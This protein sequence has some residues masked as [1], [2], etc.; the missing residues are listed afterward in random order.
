MSNFENKKFVHETAYRGE[1]ALQKLGQIHVTIAGA[2]TLGSNL[3]VSLVRQGIKNMRVIDMDR[4]EEQNLGTQV[5][6]AS[7]V[8]AL[9]VDAL[10]N[11]VYQNVECEIESINKELTAKNIKKLLKNTD[12]VIDAFDN[13][14]SRR[15]L[16]EYCSGN[17]IACLHAGLFEDYGEVVWNENYIVPDDVNGDVCDYP[18][19]RNLAMLVVSVAAEELVD[20][21]TSE[22]PRFGSW[23]ITLKDLQIST[24]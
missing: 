3:A 7:D 10:K 17:S 15:Q 14:Q 19:A 18:L 9:K 23:S 21:A 1:S 16:F 5:Y 24:Y 4:V 6:G 22:T 11:I 20:F 8:G 12:V 13:S 2:G